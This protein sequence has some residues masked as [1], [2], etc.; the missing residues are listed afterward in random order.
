VLVCRNIL[1]VIF[2][3]LVET[4][5]A[6]FA[7]ICVVLILLFSLSQAWLALI[8]ARSKTNLAVAAED[9]PLPKLLPTVL[10]QL[11]I[12]NEKYVVERLLRSAAC[13][14]YPAHL[15]T[16][17]LLDDSTDETSEIASQIIADIT[18][19]GG[20]PIYYIRRPNREGYKAGALQYGLDLAKNEFVAVFDADFLPRASFI[21]DVLKYF[22]DPKVGMVQTRWEH[23]NLNYSAL[24]KLL[25]FAIDNHFSVEQGGRQAGNCFINFNGT[26]G[27]WRR[28]AIDE[29]GGWS[30]DCLTEDLDLSFRSRVG[31]F[32]MLKKSR[33]LRN[34]Q[35]KWPQFGLNKRAGQKVR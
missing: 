19:N 27:M 20:I 7:F 14:D 31:N 15:L 23:I 24:T 3:I 9:H 10:I 25:A 2:L 6:L 21:K 33:P 26:A 35:S 18:K 11:P 30:A 17:Q 13:L 29:C 12:Y 28:S 32:F 34:C 8:Y 16:I 4:L 5:L 22:A 1:G